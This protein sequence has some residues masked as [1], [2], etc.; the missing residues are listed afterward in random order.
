MYTL[1]NLKY[2]RKDILDMS[3]L[4]QVG[5]IPS[6]LSMVDYLAVLFN[7][8][9]NPSITTIVLGKPFG[10]QAYYAIFAELGLIDKNWNLYGTSLEEWRY[11]IGREHRL[12]KF[13]DDTMGNALGVA[14]GICLRN[15]N[16]VYVNL[17]DASIQEGSVWEAIM[18]ASHQNLGNLIVT[19][20]NNNMQVLGNVSDVLGISP[21]GKK[22]K[23]FG[24]RVF[25]GDGH[26]ITDI[27]NIYLR[28]FRSNKMN[29]PTVIIFNTIKGK[30]I[31]FM[32]NN[33]DWHYKLLD[34]DVYKMALQE[35]V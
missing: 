31:S 35:I 5:H 6:A 34:D 16:L 21:L 15:K 32:E 18:F 22:F 9:L 25:E 17:S 33:K 27:E 24:W 19:I 13:I 11:I 1:D 30:G 2:I 12:I 28:A 20:D 8:F 29:Q 23:S 3:Y 26:K 7:K 10:A 14:C 4:A